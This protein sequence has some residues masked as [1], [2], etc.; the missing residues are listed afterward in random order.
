MKNPTGRVLS[1]LIL[2]CAPA[3]WSQTFTQVTPGPSGVSASAD[4]GN[5][6]ANVVDKNLATRWSAQ[7]DGQWLQLDLGSEHNVG[8][9]R[10]AVFN[11]TTRSNIFDLQTSTG[12]GVWQAAFSGQS[13]QGSNAL[14][15]FDF[16]PRPA[17]F[18]RYFGHGNTGSTWN[19][20]TE[21]EVY[22]VTTE[23]SCAS[24]FNVGG[25]ASQWVFYDT[26][27]R[28]SYRNVDSRGDHILD[29]SHAGYKG[30]GVALPSAPVRVTL[31]AN[32]SG[33]DTSRIQAAI[34]QVAGMAADAQGIRGAVQLNAGTYRLSGTLTIGASG[35]TLRGAGSTTSG[36]VINLTGAE[37]TF[38]TLAG[39]GSWEQSGAV[40][41]TSSYVPSG[42]RSF[43]VSSASGFAVGQAVIVE[44]PVTSAWVHFMDM[45]TLVRDGSPQTWIGTSTRIKTDRVI[46]AISGNTI[47]LDVPLSDSF[48]ANLVPG[49]TL[50]RY[51][52]PG[53]ISQAGVESLRVIAPPGTPDNPTNFKLLSVSAVIDGWVK[54]VFGQDMRAGASVSDTAKRITLDRVTLNHTIPS[55]SSAKPGDFGV[56][57]TQ[58][59]LSRCKST[60]AGGVYY[61]LTQST[62]TGPV[63]FLDFQATGGIAV[64]PH[65]RWATGL[66]VDRADV[67]GQIDLM[68]RGIFGSGHGWTIGWGVAW[69][70]VT[71]SFVVQR[72]PGAPNWSIG[73]R[74]NIKDQPRPGRSSPNE[75]R[76]IFDSHGTPVAPNSL[77]LA[78]LCDRLGMQAVT[79]IGY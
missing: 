70:S 67:A 9:V 56:S 18:V 1:A 16:T 19:S 42:S 31:S 28:L 7:G 36:T 50:S 55:T 76:G 79:N 52:F 34:N 26:S 40:N 39:S 20:V 74:G 44:R 71:G 53:R 21:I 65:Q 32:A 35:V 59:L 68:N 64:E 27:G 33:D 14:Q 48:D 66:L 5:V 24:R 57:G 10:V 23:Q 8:R 62:D 75:P 69:N 13:T 11:G 30:G 41:I 37:H 49:A 22:E 60:N 2:A 6:P 58:T 38:I 51:S 78:Q 61:A 3:A 54:D 29:F 45:D 63:V 47:T 25:P 15:N 73:G 4:D 12:G 43:T 77:Y 72:P 46:S 17:R